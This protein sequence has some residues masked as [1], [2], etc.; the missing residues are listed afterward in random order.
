MK[1]SIPKMSPSKS[2]FGFS[3]FVSA[4]TNIKQTTW[5]SNRKKVLTKI[6]EGRVCFM[7]NDGFSW[8]TSPEKIWFWNI[9]VKS[10]LTILDHVL[11]KSFKQL[12][13]PSISSGFWFNVK[14]LWHSH[15]FQGSLVSSRRSKCVTVS[16]FGSVNNSTGTMEMCGWAQRRPKSFGG[17]K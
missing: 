9:S 14:F 17:N 4:A 8:E 15:D 6:S 10:I 3:G 2:A 11:N 7:G 12:K 1:P 16:T 5:P 13:N